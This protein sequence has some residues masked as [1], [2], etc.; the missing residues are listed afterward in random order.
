M[1]RSAS[2][3]RAISTAISRRTSSS[4]TTAPSAPPSRAGFR[5]YA[6]GVTTGIRAIA[7]LALAL[8]FACSATEPTACEDFADL[9]DRIQSGQDPYSD[10]SIDDLQSIAD[11]AQDEG[12]DI[13]DAGTYLDVSIQAAATF[14]ERDS[15]APSI[16]RFTKA[17]G[18]D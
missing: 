9:T 13:A 1:R 15:I 2:S 16:K 3:W 6:K 17:C 8:L 11:K 18:L 5:P 14:D 12:G 7:T 4:S 10:E